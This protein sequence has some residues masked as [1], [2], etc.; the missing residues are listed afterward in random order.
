MNQKISTVVAPVS[1][2]R[3]LRRSPMLQQSGFL[4]RFTRKLGRA[5]L[6]VLLGSQGRR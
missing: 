2:Q 4:T 1:L 3:K 6:N 5:S